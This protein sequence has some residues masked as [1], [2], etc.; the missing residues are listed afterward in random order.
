MANAAALYFMTEYGVILDQ[1]MIG[2]ILNT[3]FQE[4]TEL[5]DI[6]ILP[7][8]LLLG[9][10]PAIVI[11]NIKIIKPKLRSKIEYLFASLIFFM[12]SIY[13]FASTWI[14]Y[15]CY[16]SS[17]SDRVLPWAYIIHL[18]DKLHS[19][20]F[21]KQEPVSLPHAIFLSEPVRKQVVVLV[22]GESV[23]ADHLAHYGYLKDTNPYTKNL[24]LIVFKE[25]L[26][27][28][29][30]TISSTACL[31]SYEGS[32]VSKGVNSDP[33]QSYLTEHNITTILRS[34]N[35]GLPDLKTTK[36]EDALS[37]F[38]ACKDKDCPATKDESLNWKLDEVIKK[39]TASRIFITLHQK[40]SHGPA[41]W[42]RY[43]HEFEYFT[44]VCR[45]S[46]VKA[47]SS[48]MINN[49]YDNSLRYTDKLLANIIAQLNS[50]ADVDSV[51]FYVSD[52]GESLGEGG[53]FFHAAPNVIA[54]KE[55][56]NIPFLVWLSSGFKQAHGLEGKAIITQQTFP[57]DFV[58]HSIMGAFEMR[59][60]IYKSEF[61]IFNFT[62][63]G[64]SRIG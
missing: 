24:N 56:F 26:S 3:N 17:I 23:R 19:N 33:I 49:A 16:I 4:A 43:P 6:A 55:Q 22:I 51:M 21:P 14:W 44:P 11:W 28:A 18:G 7:Y 27:C 58:F 45:T 25:G 40:G 15:D 30:N 48:E 50:L 20:I 62:A 2:N 64:P 42:K 38:H 29:T 53:F 13:A 41:Y 39:S 5:L 60:D 12:I 63:A 47:C 9:I 61:D 36:S 57:H 31:L 35:D 37:I 1:T 52:H 54:P 32:Q 46:Y 8:I 10:A 59:S 34:N